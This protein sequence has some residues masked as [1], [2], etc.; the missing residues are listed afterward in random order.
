MKRT[1]HRLVQFLQKYIRALGSSAWL[2]TFGLARGKNRGRLAELA[3]FFG[4]KNPE[5]SH[6]INF[7]DSAI[8]DLIPGDTALSFRDFEGQDGNVSP[9]ELI[10]L[11][12]LVR[13]K[14]PRALFEFGTFDGRTTLHLALNAPQNARIFTLDLPDDKVAEARRNPDG[15]VKFAGKVAVGFRYK[16]TLQ[17][18][19]I[20]ELKG[21]S[22]HFDFSPYARS[23]D[24]AFIDGAHSFSYVMSD[25]KNALAMLAEGGIILWHDCRPSCAGVT[26]ALNKFFAEDLRFK[27][28]R[29]IRGT[30]LAILFL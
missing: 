7:P 20:T 29:R 5:K 15:D 27:N 10:V 6:P 17:E 2:L 30:N 1:I 24:F 25:T 4:W 9:L 23:I 13:K 3:E 26:R 21:D 8:A 22:L 19:S 12:A 14:K 18:H 16:G 11:S 28:L